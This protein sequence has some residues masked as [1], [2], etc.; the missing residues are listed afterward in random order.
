MVV[1]RN[2][3][4]RHRKGTWSS[5]R[6]HS[7]AG[8]TRSGAMVLVP[9]AALTFGRHCHALGWS[10]TSPPWRLGQRTWFP[11]CWSIARTAATCWQS[12]PLRQE[13]S[14]SQTGRR[15]LSDTSRLSQMR[16]LSRSLRFPKQAGSHGNSATSWRGPAGSRGAARTRAERHDARRRTVECQAQAGCVCDD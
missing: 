8:S 12:T 6:T 1:S 2:T 3:E 11:C 16:Q 14:E 9:F 5:I 10:Q 13:S 15:S 7:V 4:H